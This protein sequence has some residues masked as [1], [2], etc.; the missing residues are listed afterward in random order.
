[1]LTSIP[2][3]ERLAPSGSNLVGV[4]SARVLRCPVA[5]ERRLAPIAPDGAQRDRDRQRRR[6]V[7]GCLRSAAADPTLAAATPSTSSRASVIEAACAPVPDPRVRILFPFGFRGC[8]VRSSASRCCAGL[9]RPEPAS[10]CSCIRSTAPGSRSAPRSCVRRRLGA[11]SRRRLRPVPDV[12]RAA[13]HHRVPGRRRSAPPAG[14]CPRCVAH[15]AR[16]DDPAPTR[17][18]ARVA[19]VLGRE[20]RYPTTRSRST[21]ARRRAARCRQQAA[22]RR[23]GG[24]GLRLRLARTPS[25]APT[26]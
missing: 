2:S 3:R 20:H 25:A 13:L 6:R 18:H 19:C 23:A 7:L 15:R 21:S 5:P 8:R 22:A 11:A 26:T 10:A 14:T 17:C 24:A 12:P 9:G 1:M 16:P 4:A